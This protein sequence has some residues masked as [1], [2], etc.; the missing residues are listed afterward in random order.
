MDYARYQKIAREQIKKY[1]QIVTFSLAA[2]PASYNPVLGQ[3]EQEFLEVEAHAVLA[4]P[5]ERGFRGGTL[6]IGDAVLLVDGGTL[7][8]APSET[9][10]VFV[11][12]AEWRVLGSDRVSPAGL[13]I[14]YKVYI[15]RS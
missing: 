5:S 11:E 14:I 12:G 4:S 6:H 9:D 7:P 1:G 3:N 15:R 13:V 8:Q 10:T 2:G